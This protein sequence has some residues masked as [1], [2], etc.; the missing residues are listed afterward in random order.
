MLPG[1]A[2]FD[3]TAG[4]LGL[5]GVILGATLRLRRV[6][7]GLMSV[8]TERAGDLDDLLARFTA[9]GDRLPY[10][11]AWVDLMARGR[12]TGRGILT[13]GARDP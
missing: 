11:S 10:A 7:T 5:T 9:G 13:R 8:S 4:G 2:L 1:T 3:A 12:A 6:T